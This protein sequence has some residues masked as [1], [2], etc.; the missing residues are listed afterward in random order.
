MNVRQLIG[1][2][3]RGYRNKL[4]ISQEKLS[5]LA[6]TD[7]AYIGI[8]ERGEKSVS[9]EVLFRIGLALKIEPHLLMLKDS[10]RTYQYQKAV[11]DKFIK[12]KSS[13]GARKSI[14]K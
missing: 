7:R 3:I 6:N 5:E 4:G 8:V 10:H 1:D 11:L 9:A 2:N 13:R 14:S 12:P